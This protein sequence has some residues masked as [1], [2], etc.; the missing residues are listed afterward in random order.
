MSAVPPVHPSRTPVAAALV[1]AS[2]A[3]LSVFYG[4]TVNAV[5]LL[6]AV[7]GLLTAASLLGPRRLA[8]G[9][10][11]VPWASALAVAAVVLLGLNYQLS[12]SKDSSFAASWS[13]ALIPLSFIVARALGVW[14]WRVC[15]GLGLLVLAYAAAS[16][17]SYFRQGVRPALPLADLN[18]YCTLL[19]MVLLPG[20]YAYLVRAWRSDGLAW[21]W[22]LVAHLA[23]GLIVTVVFATQSRVGTLVVATGLII[24]VGLS[25][26]RSVRKWPALSLLGMAALLYV[27]INAIQAGGGRFDAQDIGEGAQ[28]RAA[29]N[30]SALDIYREHP[31]VGAGINLFPVLYRMHRNPVDQETAGLSPHNDYLQLLAEGGPL[32]CL[33]LL[34]FALGVGVRFLQLTF[35]SDGEGPDASYGILLALGATLAHAAINFVLMTSVLACLLGLG[36]ALIPWQNVSE[37]ASSTI[38]ARLRFAV[39][40]GLCWGWLAFA[41]LALDVFSLGVYEAQ[42]GIPF[43]S[44]LRAD[45]ER[46]LAYSR[47][48]QTVNADRGVP[49]LAEAAYYQARLDE[50]PESEYLRGLTVATYRRARQVD[51]YNPAVLLQMHSLLLTHPELVSR[52][53]EGERPFDLLLAAISLDPILLPAYDRLISALE[54]Q[55]RGELAYQ[56]VKQQLGPWLVWLAT[57]NPLAAER[58]LTYLQAWAA[59]EQD[60]AYATTLK[61]LEERLRKLEFRPRQL[62][63]QGK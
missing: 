63:F 31:V 35:S 44:Q 26:V 24:F 13:L 20:T 7:F 23:V 4:M 1:F 61:A 32:M 55:G 40:G 46:T 18:N 41:Y 53:P 56:V 34:G 45:P 27:G 39:I 28:L 57:Q 5:V 16:L 38:A 51:P 6:L 14:R 58:V 9:M 54:S 42:A 37:A 8:Q 59:R 52:L 36:A 12:L 21:W 17:W 19:Y 60:A 30:M 33:V 2:I 22:H 15:A 62:W 25:L 50:K 43:A 47:F 3:G 48:V 29:L 49:V 10:A 11:E